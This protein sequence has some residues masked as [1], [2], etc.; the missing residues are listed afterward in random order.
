MIELLENIKFGLFVVGLIC[1]SILI[2]GVIWSILFPEKRLWPPPRKRSWQHL[3]TW[4]LYYILFLLNILLFFLD[5]NSWV[6]LSPYRYFIAIPII[7]LGTFLVSWGIITLGTKNTS[8]VK[9]QF[10]TQGPYQ[11][12]RNPQYL[13][14]IILFTGIIIFTNSIF[15]LIINVLLN[16]SFLI[17]PFA[18]EPW[19]KKQYGEEYI[20]Y[21]KKVP[22]FL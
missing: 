6:I 12:T 22:R 1:T 19:L 9:D 7:I 4:T 5:W 8:G 20:E 16:L 18:E 15:L 2:F 17:L 3:L 21:K 11:Y 13:G 14:D 10:K